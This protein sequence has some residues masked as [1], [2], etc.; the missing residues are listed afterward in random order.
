M[1]AFNCCLE[2]GKF[3]QQ[4]KKQRLLLL[5]K[6]NKPVDETSSYRPLC[7]LDTMGKLLEGLILLRLEKYVQFSHKQYGF[8]KGRSTTDAIL[9]VT[10]IADAA[11]KG[12]GKKKGF[13]ALVAIDIKNAFNSARWKDII[14][15]L[16]NK[17][18]PEYL[19]RVI[20]DYLRDRRVIYEDVFKIEDDM[21]CRVPQGSR[22]GP[23]L[24]NVMYDD[25]LSIE[26]PRDTQLIGYADDTL[27][28]IVTILSCWER[29]NET[30][31]RI[32]R[33]LDKKILQMAV[34]KT[35]AV[36]ITD[37]RVFTFP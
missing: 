24:W 6:G 14:E 26:Q 27:I 20:E 8:R 37:R 13:C 31:I 21:T 32:K 19:I 1:R 2:E 7:L 9:E 4:W 25:I 12:T 5:R 29:L 36:L 10:R 28:V 35:E 23:Y 22:L 18:V 17:K 3:Y 15:A 11:K 16:A 33:W 30:L 34:Q